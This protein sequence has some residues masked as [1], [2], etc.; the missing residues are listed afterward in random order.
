MK[1]LTKGKKGQI[2]GQGMAIIGLF[3]VL[4]IVGVLQTIS[5]LTVSKVDANV[6]LPLDN[7]RTTNE[8]VTITTSVP[9]GDNSTLL[10]QDG[11]I[12]NSE[13]VRNASGDLL[14][15]NTE[16][17]ITLVGDSG[18]VDT[19]ANFTLLNISSTD[20]GF[21]TSELKVSYN[22]NEETAFHTASTNLMTTSL[23]SFEL[24]S[25]AQIVL[26]AVVIL[27]SVF[28]LITIFRSR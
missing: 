14:V 22:T 9:A 12:A 27:A 26:A 2:G 21:N 24:G 15:R 23:D 4:T 13:A 3:L 11:Y 7:Q 10:A 5:V 20:G 8:S 16:Y 17:K 28:G 25:T 19:R 18:L 1:Y 6:N